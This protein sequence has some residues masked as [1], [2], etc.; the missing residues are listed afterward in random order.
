MTNNELFNPATDE[1]SYGEEVYNTKIKQG[2]VVARTYGTVVGVRYYDS[3]GQLSELVI[4]TSM[5]D[6]I[7]DSEK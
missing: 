7:N 5:Q 2:G 3:S 4:P 6:L 1:F